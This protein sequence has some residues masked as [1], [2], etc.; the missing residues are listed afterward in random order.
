[1]K[2]FNTNSNYGSM[3][4]GNAAP[5][6]NNMMSSESHSELNEQWNDLMDEYASKQGN[7]ALVTNEE[8]LK[9]RSKNNKGF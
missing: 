7:K 9:P 6:L 2:S 8:V 3:P 5:T 4:A 1:M